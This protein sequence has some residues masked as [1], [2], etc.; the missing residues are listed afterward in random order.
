[1]KTT[2]KI[3]LAA[4]LGLAVGGTAGYIVGCKL[5]K[6]K[7]DRVL[8]TSMEDLTTR[9]KAI[10]KDTIDSF[11][12]DSEAVEERTEPR[13]AFPERNAIYSTPKKPL[14]K[15]GDS[16]Q[17]GEESKSMDP[18][19]LYIV[20]PDGSFEPYPTDDADDAVPDIP[21]FAEWLWQHGATPEGIDAVNRK[22]EAKYGPANPMR[23]G[24]WHP[25]ETDSGEEVIEAP[26]QPPAPP[27]PEYPVER[28]DYAG[29]SA[30]AAKARNGDLEPHRVKEKYDYDPAAPHTNVFDE[31]EKDGR[32]GPASAPM[33]FWFGATA[34][35]M[36]QVKTFAQSVIDNANRSPDDPEYDQFLADWLDELKANHERSIDDPDFD[37][38]L[39]EVYYEEVC[40]VLADDDELER[41]H[42]EDLAKA[43]ET[44]PPT[45]PN[46]PRFTN[47]PA[48]LTQ[49]PTTGQY[50]PYF[51]DE[52]TYMRS[53]QFEKLT[54]VVY[55][56][57]GYVSL[58]D[59][60]NQLLP[61]GSEDEE[62]LLGTLDPIS[63]F[64][65]SPDAPDDEP[66][67]KI[68][69]RNV[70]QKSDIELALV[71]G[72]GNDEGCD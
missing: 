37:P 65:Q 21:P 11:S 25:A 45:H 5:Q 69:I 50:L 64:W 52:R 26:N 51:I 12:A 14:L 1:M 29:I 60:S 68:W 15:E 40:G 67:E 58:Y 53:A 8:N 56:E 31:A 27:P 66:A 46:S 3:I 55:E 36:K 20:H 48:K 23:D 30:K 18:N 24:F 72:D 34:D 28:V 63:L 35:Q 42:G 22:L 61:L 43:A 70:K 32:L 44:L 39:D 6:A 57:N 49:D 17:M 71:P 62:R 13:M 9:Y 2:T 10:V 41:I 16:L 47:Y 7:D 59:N 54:G 4:G 38:E 19:L 33:P